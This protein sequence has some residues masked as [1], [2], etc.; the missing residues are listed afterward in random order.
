MEPIAIVGTGCRFPGS[1]S[2]PA[3]LW[4]LL[5]NP[6][7]VGSTVPA[8]RFNISAFYHENGSNHGTTNASE[9]YFLTEDFRRFDASFFNISASEAVSIDPQQRILLETVY[10]SIEAAGIPMG[11]LRGSDTAV[12]AGVMCDDYGQM[13]LFV[14]FPYNYYC[15]FCM[16]APKAAAVLRACKQIIMSICDRVSLPKTT[17]NSR[18]LAKTAF[19]HANEMTARILTHYRDI[20]RQELQGPL[21]QTGSHTS[22]IG[23]GRQLLLIR[24]AHPVW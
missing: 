22:L 6:R 21:S 9:A 13:L 12:F 10:E 14:S 20:L 15:F 7:H 8:D 3:R 24:P 17:P 2:S 18:A 4:E 16:G 19:Q 23:T 5:R 11:D 1:S